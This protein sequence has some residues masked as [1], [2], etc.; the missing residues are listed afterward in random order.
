MSAHHSN[1]VL[2]SV[3]GSSEADHALT[4]YANTMWK[5]TDKVVLV[6]CPEW[7][8]LTDASP[9]VIQD[10]SKKIESH[11][12]DVRRHYEEMMQKL[13]I[14]GKF[15]VVNCSK[16]GHGVI[17]MIDEVKATYVLTGTRG[18]GKIRRTILG[19]VSDYIVH[20]SPVPVVVARR[21][22]QHKHEEREDGE[23]KPM[24]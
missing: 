13:K 16:P 8:D 15:R 11:S 5:D 21:E 3:D 14:N 6:Y 1:T 9:G 7:Y 23:F 22:K 4:W 20:H 10:L 18:Q 12:M 24:V 19:S 2:I 17:T